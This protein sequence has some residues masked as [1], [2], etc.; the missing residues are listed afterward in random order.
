[1]F[2]YKGE[3]E[4]LQNLEGIFFKKC[5]FA[6]RYGGSRR[7]D[8]GYVVIPYHSP[9]IPPFSEEVQLSRNKGE[10]TPPHKKSEQKLTYNREV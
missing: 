7:G 3:L 2:K 8:V 10:I 1:M 5:T 4:T 9:K 6:D